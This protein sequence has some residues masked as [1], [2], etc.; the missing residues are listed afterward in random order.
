VRSPLS[1]FESNIRGTWT[2]LEAIR[3]C[4]KLV[5]RVVVASSDKAYG[6]QTQLPYTEDM[7]LAGRFPYDVSKS[8]TDLI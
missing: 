6:D 8:C 3:Q 7:P 1:T 4:P 2:L 5:E